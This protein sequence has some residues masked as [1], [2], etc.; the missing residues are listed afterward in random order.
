[1]H[2]K[3]A[4]TEEELEQIFRLN[5]RTF[6]EEIPQHERR[7]DERLVD[8]FHNQ[9]TYFIAKI[10]GRVLG[11]VC[12][13]GSRP[14]SLDK[15][16]S[17]LDKLLPPHKKMAEVR[18]LAVDPSARKTYVAFK[19]LKELIQ[20]LL[21]NGFDFAI[22]SAILKEMDMYKKV[23]FVAFGPTVGKEGALYQPMYIDTNKLT[24]YFKND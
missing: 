20:H 5:Y 10:E 17:E 15:K 19:L 11:M 21:K 1:M 9:N 14:F 4:V 24:E 2:I 16:I 23:G 12:Y 8:A 7:E 18:L 22:I 6:V 13:N 3:I